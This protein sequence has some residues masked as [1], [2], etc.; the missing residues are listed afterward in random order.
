MCVLE[1]VIIKED[2]SMVIV[3]GD[4]NTTLAGALVS[5]KLHIPIIHVEAGLRSFNKTMPEEI[6]RIV[7]DHISDYLFA[8]T[9]AA[10]NNL[11]NEGLTERT[12]ITGDIMVDALAN[13]IDKAKKRSDIVERYNLEKSGYYLLTLHRPYNVDDPY[14]LSKIFNILS[15]LNKKVI[16]PVHPRTKKVIET[17]GILIPDII[18]ITNPI[19]YIDFLALEYFSSKIITDSGGVQKEA[20]ILKK[21]CITIRSETE[22]LETVESGW[23]ILVDVESDYFIDAI[24][25]FNP[26]KEQ[27]DIFGKNVANK[28]F[29]IIKQIMSV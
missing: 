28:M 9:K 17:Y 12:M 23:N 10:A 7:T 25:T 20:Y 5:A 6:N 21:P 14:N 2:P 24:E 26:S 3:F 29:S 11:H 16:F 4:T 13:N 22:W 8:P 27:S 1:E 15:S 18:V 19:G